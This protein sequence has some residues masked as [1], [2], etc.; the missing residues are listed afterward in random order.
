MKIGKQTFTDTV[1]GAE[2]EMTFSISDDNPIIF[3]I[4]RDKMY[5]NKI[6]SICREVAS[7][8]RDANRESGKADTPIT[9]EIIKPD[10][11]MY[12]GEESI[13]FQDNGIGI[14]PDRMENIFVK[15]AASTKRDTNGQTGGF[16]LGAKTP[17][18]YTD[19]S[20]VVT[21]CLFLV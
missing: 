2:K 6:G 9:I 10:Q 14:T 5:S 19:T 13:C 12:I 15:Y 4:L 8:S 11:L 20:T 18:A 17:F 16:G 3:E 7:N 21:V 1:L